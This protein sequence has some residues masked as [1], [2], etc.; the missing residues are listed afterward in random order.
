MD[1]I[2]NIVV[3]A[4]LIEDKELMDDVNGQPLG[5]DCYRVSIQVVL[6]GAAF[7][8]EPKDDEVVQV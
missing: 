5:D 6:N 8:P 4:T 2:E 3:V 7:L 1:S